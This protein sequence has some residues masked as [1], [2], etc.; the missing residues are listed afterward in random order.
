MDQCMS[1]SFKEGVNVT[2]ITKPLDTLSDDELRVLIAAAQ[3]ILRTRARKT[4]ISADPATGMW[5]DRKDMQDSVAWVRREREQWNKRLT[6]E[7]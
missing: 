1:R 5:A 4:P 3:A 7:S 6:R 2:D